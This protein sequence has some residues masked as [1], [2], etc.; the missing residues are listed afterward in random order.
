MNILAFSVQHTVKEYI[1]QNVSAVFVYK[2]INVVLNNNLHS[3]GL[4]C[5]A[6]LNLWENCP[7]KEIHGA[8]KPSCSQNFF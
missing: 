8:A 4:E 7:F 5:H 3:M 1:L 6:N 2:K